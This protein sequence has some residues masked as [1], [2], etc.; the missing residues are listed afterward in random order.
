MYFAPQ[1]F[2]G[3]QI[4]KGD[5]IV[6]ME[7]KDDWD[8]LI[9]SEVPIILE[10]GAS[11]CGPCRMLKPMMTTIAKDYPSVQLVYMD[12]DKFPQVAQMLEIQH[13]PKT[14]LLYQGDLVDSFGGV[15]QDSSKIHDFFKKAKNLGENIDEDASQETSRGESTGTAER[16]GF[17]IE[18][19]NETT[20]P[21]V[22]KGSMVTVHYT[23]KLLNGTVFDS[24][25]HR[26]QP[27][28]FQV[29]VGQVI[30]GWDEGV[31]LLRKG[32]KAILTC[33]PEYAYGSRGA[34][35][36]IPPNATLIFEVEVLDFK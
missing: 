34:G 24:S 31:L 33:P 8:A 3:I 28:Q 23:G 11:W 35:G 29:G 14:F 17:F 10:T 1:R 26:N 21:T 6:E 22:P 2:F 32:E 30:R 19:Q 5:A 7:S 20:G 12:V 16:Q 15:P 27:F 4:G 13:I 36:V 18:K 9:E 25:L